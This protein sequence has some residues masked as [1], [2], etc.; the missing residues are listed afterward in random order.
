[1]KV[2][3]ITDMN[4]LLGKSS[5]SIQQSHNYAKKFA[6]EKSRKMFLKQRKTPAFLTYDANLIRLVKRNKNPVYAVVPDVSQYVRDLNNY[7]LVKMG[8]KKLMQIGLDLPFL[9]P[10]GMKKGLGVLGKD[11]NSILC[12]LT[13]VEMVKFRKL[14]PQIVFL[15]PQMTDLFLANNNPEPLRTFISFVQK[16]YHT[17]AGLFTNNVGVLLKKT[18]QW[19]LPLEYVCT[20]L[21]SRGYLMK[22]SKK[23]VEKILR[24]SSIT[25]FAY[26]VTCGGTIPFK[27]AQKYVQGMGVEKIIIETT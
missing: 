25:F 6:T 7:G 14:K 18:E 26:D 24:K 22:P 9:L 27:E 15:H 1:M 19:K 20:P 8:I 12:V 13:A 2:S 23:E 11:M 21:N 10:V 16:T 5:K 3:V 4:P 17:Q